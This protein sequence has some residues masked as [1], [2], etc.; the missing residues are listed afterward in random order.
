MAWIETNEGALLHCE[1]GNKIV[2]TTVGL[3]ENVRSAIQWKSTDG[4]TIPI[5]TGKHNYISEKMKL[6]RLALLPNPVLRFSNEKETPST[7]SDE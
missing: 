3:G 1:T 7:D 5:C 2:R 6:L 4:T